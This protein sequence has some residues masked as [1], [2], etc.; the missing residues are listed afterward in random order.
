MTTMIC[1]QCAAQFETRAG[2]VN[3]AAK[4]GAPLYCGR[5][6]AG[7]ARRLPM[8][9][10]AEQKKAEKAA[11]DREYRERIGDKLAAKKRAWYEANRPQVLAQM[12]EYRKT[13]MPQHVEYCRR[14]EYRA[15]K[16]EYDRKRNEAKYQEWAD[17]W[18]L[19]LDLEKEIRSRATAY[20]RRVANGYYTRNAQ[21]RRR[22][23]WMLR[24]TL[25][26]TP[27]TSSRNSGRR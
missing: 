27:A 3:R 2:H 6:C 4:T 11:Y 17:A 1:P 7:M 14:P 13:R 21:K 16:H 26:L 10:S 5:A 20:E 22:E 18:R 24:K 8:P 19:L 23:L 12:T 15:L 9:K 25:N